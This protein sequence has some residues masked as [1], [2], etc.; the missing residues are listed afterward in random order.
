MSPRRLLAALFFVHI[1]GAGAWVPFLGLHLE[2]TV[3]QGAIIGALLAL[4]PAAR[5][6]SAPLWSLVAD[7]FR[8][9]RG[10]LRLA[11]TSS[12]V[13]AAAIAFLD[14]EPLALG[15]ALVTFSALRAPIGPL[16]DSAA[17]RLIVEE[18]GNPQDYGRLRLWGTVGFLALS[19]AAAM[20]VDG[21]AGAS[22][23]LGMAVGAWVLSAGMTFLLPAAPPS[24]PA[25]IL[26]ALRRLARSPFLGPMLVALAL[27]GMG[28]TLYDSLL[29]VH[30]EARGM[31]GGWVA[32][33]LGF[34]LVTEIAVMAWGGRLLA[35][36][37][38]FPLLTF[39]AAVGVLR[40]VATALV[41]LPLALVAL[42]SLHGIS[43]AVFWIAGVEVMRRHAPEEVQASA[44]ALLT[45]TSY[46]VGALLSSGAVAL[47]LDRWGTPGLFLVAAGAG[48]LATAGLWLA[49]RRAPERPRDAAG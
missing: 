10:M 23:A 31:T 24:A 15:L 39:A 1:G 49:Q 7:R 48:V 5:M 35:R 21:E 40:W 42:Q 2:R 19:G 45:S 36:W 6:L 32:L 28:L 38:A 34:G 18:G 8:S 30:L 27:H 11:T 25:P 12:I 13:A 22:L 47:M 37:G 33:A 16:L 26:P 17:V 29:A 4:S 14:L 44:Q 20:L 3:H 43:F 9:G 41:T 46:G